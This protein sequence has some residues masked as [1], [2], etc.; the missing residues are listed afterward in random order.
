MITLKELD[1]DLPPERIAAVPSAQRDE[2]RLLVVNRATK[3]ISHHYF[4][5]LPNLIP[6]AYYFFRNS[7]RVLKARLFGVRPDGWKSGMPVT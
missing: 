6:A 2:S 3:K 7:V 5:E 1:F 4:R